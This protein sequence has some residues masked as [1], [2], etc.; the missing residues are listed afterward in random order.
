MLTAPRRW[1]EELPLLL[2]E[3]GA[4]VA[5]EGQTSLFLLLV[6]D[7][8]GGNNKAVR[9]E[10]LGKALSLWERELHTILGYTDNKMEC[11][12]LSPQP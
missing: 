4:G 8:R 7:A 9:Q 10:V 5:G 2:A 6:V 11:R 12:A 3:L 1:G